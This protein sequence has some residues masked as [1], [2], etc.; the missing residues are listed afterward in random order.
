M[1]HRSDIRAALTTGGDPTSPLILPLL[2]RHAARV[3]QVTP[4]AMLTNPDTAARALLAAQRLYDLDVVI[5]G[6]ALDLVALAARAA[7]APN[8]PPPLARRHHE[9][10]EALPGLP[11]PDDLA[12]TTPVTTATALLKRLRA[13]LAHRAATA[14]ALPTAADLATSLGHPGETAWA[15]DACGAVLRTVGEV[16]PDAVLQAGAGGWSPRLPTLCDYFG[17]ALLRAGETGS[18]PGV[19]APPG[20]AFP[21]L[22]PGAGWIYTTRTEI[23]PDTNPK[24]LT[25]TITRLRAPSPA[26][27]QP[28]T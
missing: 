3:E 21:D 16:E 4:A 24:R 19:V 13:L 28:S 6:G 8:E 27:D 9:R 2:E 26:P 22:E 18:T 15:E 23:P 17:A 5:V 25:T 20:D 7:V 1:T 14:L 12:T 11:D 10:G